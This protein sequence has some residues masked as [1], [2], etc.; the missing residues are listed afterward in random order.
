MTSKPAHL[1]LSPV[2]FLSPL[3]ARR[4]QGQDAA[5]ESTAYTAWY[6]ASQ[7]KEVAKACD[8]AGQYLAK[9]PSGQYADF[10]KK[11]VSGARGALFNEAIKAKDMDAMIRVGKERLAESPDDLDYLLGMALNLRIN[12]LFAN[13]P[14]DAHAAEVTEL[15]KRAVDLIEGGKLPTGADPSKWKRDDTLAWLYQNQAIVAM[16]RDRD[17][18]ALQHFEKSTRLAATN[19]VLKT[20]NSLYCGSLR[21]Q[22]YDAAVA[23]F[24]ALPEAERADT[25]SEAA[26]AAIEQANKEAD[27]AIDCWARFVA[28]A[29][30]QNAS[31]DVRARISKTAADLYAYRNPQDPEGFRKLVDGH[32][33]GQAAPG[34]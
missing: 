22:K 34:K 25:P 28:L 18:T 31:E 32:K 27:A 8:L 10:L 21:K 30:A 12:E 19:P 1:M 29:E 13:P 26:K 11:W 15:S 16:K 14:K 17:D 33:Q 23:R 24:Q 6:A 2:V 5:D 7:A 3:A 4:A 9:F 20:Y